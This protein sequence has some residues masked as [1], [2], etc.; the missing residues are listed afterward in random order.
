MLGRKKYVYSENIVR[1]SRALR[2]SFQGLMGGTYIPSKGEKTYQVCRTYSVLKISSALAELYLEAS[3]T[4]NSGWC[5]Y[6]SISMQIYSSTALEALQ[7]HRL[8]RLRTTINIVVLLTPKYNTSCI[9]VSDFPL[10]DRLS[11]KYTRLVAVFTAYTRPVGDARHRVL[12]RRSFT[13]A[14]PCAQFGWL[15]LVVLDAD[16]A[17]ACRREIRDFRGSS[18]GVHR[19]LEQRGKTTR[20]R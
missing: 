13:P 19:Q 10:G 5:L 20:H 6:S 4:I 3:R 15:A 16:P 8:Q 17:A 12:S 11:R 18:G 9:I 14:F 7:Q 2:R 1:P